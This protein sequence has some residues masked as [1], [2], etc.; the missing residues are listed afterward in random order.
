MSELREALRVAALLE[1]MVRNYGRRGH[2]W[3][4]LDSEACADAAKLLRSRAAEPVAWRYRYHSE[5][6]WTLQSNNP[7]VSDN[8]NFKAQPTCY[9]TAT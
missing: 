6:A 3:D 4:H 1:A 2:H 8:P 9:E 5:G 7:G